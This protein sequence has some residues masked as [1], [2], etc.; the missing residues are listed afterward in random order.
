MFNQYRETSNQRG[1]GLIISDRMS[2][3][4]TLLIWLGNINLITAVLH[5]MCSLIYGEHLHC[6]FFLT[7][8]T[9]LPRDETG[10]A[11]GAQIHPHPIPS[12][13]FSPVHFDH[14]G[15]THNQV[16]VYVYTP[17]NSNERTPIN[18]VF[19]IPCSSGGLRCPCFQ[20]RSTPALNCGSQLIATWGHCRVPKTGK[21]STQEPFIYPSKVECQVNSDI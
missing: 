18:N 7:T 8:D 5:K 14:L 21:V 10:Y 15:P 19:P 3:S 2:A 16:C 12:T 9:V 6:F 4:N 13:Q 17:T 11:T 20:G 1:I